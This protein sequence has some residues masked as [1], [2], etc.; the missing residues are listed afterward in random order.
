MS[1]QF[2]FSV[3]SSILKIYKPFVQIISWFFILY[4]ISD[5]IT[6]LKIKLGYFLRLAHRIK[7]IL[8]HHTGVLCNYKS[9]FRNLLHHCRPLSSSFKLIIWLIVDFFEFFI[10]AYSGEFVFVMYNLPESSYR[11]RCINAPLW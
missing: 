5:P 1:L 2:V 8:F 11:G 9:R 7:Q 10:S 4:F 6:L 3:I